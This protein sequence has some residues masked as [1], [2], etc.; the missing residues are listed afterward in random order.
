MSKLNI[1][2]ISDLKTEKSRSDNKVSRQYYTL[3]VA[4]AA[5]PFTGTGQRTIFQNHSQDG[6]TAFWKGADFNQA[7]ALVGTQIEGDV[8]R[9][10]VEPYDINGRMASSFTCVVLKGE[11]AEAIASQAG[12]STLNKAIVAPVKETV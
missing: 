7:K 10:E 8:T 2:R 4:D 11:S 1:V 6:K 9:L 12:H 5:N 3:Y